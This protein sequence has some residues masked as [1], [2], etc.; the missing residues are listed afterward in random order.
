MLSRRIAR[1][2]PLRQAALAARRLPAVQQRSFIPSS[3]TGPAV[4]EEKYPDSDYPRLTEKEDPE[5]VRPRSPGPQYFW[6]DQKCRA[7]SGPER[8]F[9]PACPD[10]AT[11]PRSPCRLVGQAREE[12]LW[13]AGARG[14]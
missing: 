2:V 1:A 5:M 11:V 7:N 9:R 12:E 13:R 10:Q 4:I 6:G 8:W 3:M 14:P